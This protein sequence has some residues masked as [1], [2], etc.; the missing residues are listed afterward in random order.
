M[1]ETYARMLHG[2]RCES[3]VRVCLHTCLKACLGLASADDVPRARRQWHRADLRIHKLLT[4]EK[5]ELGVSLGLAAERARGMAELSTA[6]D[7]RWFM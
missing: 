4:I 3:A 7:L 2:W 6:A 5:D 1:L